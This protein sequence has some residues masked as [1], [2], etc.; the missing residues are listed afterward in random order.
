MTYIC[1]MKYIN[2][3]ELAKRM[4]YSSYNSFINSKTN[5]DLLIKLVEYIESEVIK[6]YENRLLLKD[7]EFVKDLELFSTK[8]K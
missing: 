6:D 3:A 7:R 5:K 4:G 2:K 8:Y 1:S